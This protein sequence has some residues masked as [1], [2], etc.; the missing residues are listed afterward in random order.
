MPFQFDPDLI[1]WRLHLHSP[2]D[3]VY[4]ALSTDAGRASFWAESAVER[5]GII[6]YI[7]PNGITWDVLIV[8][9][10][11][12]RRYAIR[13]YGDSLVTFELEDDGQGGT[14]LTLTD[15][16]VPSPDRTEVIAGWV[17]VLLALKAAVD[18]GVDLRA[19]DPDRHWDTGYVEN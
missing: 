11:P 9:A 13:Y 4:R 17:S 3:A 6:H 12:P 2:P 10:I 7:F 8:E 14:D 19:H 18:F 1:R 15:R 16:G 5:D